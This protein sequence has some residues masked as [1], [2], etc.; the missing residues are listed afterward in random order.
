MLQGLGLLQVALGCVLASGM[1]FGIMLFLYLVVAGC[2]IASHERHVQSRPGAGVVAE[3]S[4]DANKGANGT[5]AAHGLVSPSGRRWRFALRWATGVALIVAVLYAATPRTEGPDWDPLARFGVQP[6]KLR[7]QTGF[8][9]EIDLTRVGRLENDTSVAFT[10]RV[11]DRAGR[12]V[13]ALLENQRFRGLIL[14]LYS[15]GKWKQVTELK[16]PQRGPR[17]AAP[18]ATSERADVLFLKFRVPR[19]T[20]GLFL[21]E[22]ITPAS[23]PHSLP[24]AEEESFS[25][26]RFALFYEASGCGTV[27]PTTF[28]TDP[29]YRY[30]QTFHGTASRERYAAVRVTS[31]YQ[32][33]ITGASAQ[34]K[35]WSIDLV[36][37]MDPQR[38]SEAKNLLP[39]LE[40]MREPASYLAPVYYE[41]LAR[42]YA[43][44]LSHSGEY[45]WSLDSFRE[46]KQIDPVLDFLKNVKQ[47]PCDRFASALALLLRAHLI[48]AR[49]VRGYRGAEYQG[50][51]NYVVFNNHAHAWVEL[52]V[53]SRSGSGYDWLILDPSPPEAGPS[54]TALVRLQRS[55]QALWRDLLLGY[56]E[57]ESI[58]FWEDLLSGRLLSSLAPTI[59]LVTVLASLAWVVRRRRKRTVRRRKSGTLYHR[60]VEL[61]AGQTGIEPAPEETPIEW[62]TRVSAWL[63]KRPGTAALADVPAHVVAVYYHLRFGGASPEKAGLREATLRLDA[64]A[65]ALRRS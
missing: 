37:R 33:R 52:L 64:L 1:I 58:N 62:A 57:G 61:L 60:L 53:P 38:F 22:P 11:E 46:D 28:L 25:P 15:E 31:S 26:R 6:P 40:R 20:N 29:E 24:V 50:D 5:N 36:R 7:L 10:V 3:T 65:Q 8:S 48:P 19:E 54:T 59:G 9:D 12:P 44:Y 2:A 18:P 42:L 41:P 49:L 4:Q 16:W 45:T 39:Q 30:V 13:R 27:M 35:E 21:A 56:R 43:D 32:S 63:E 23:D 55:S 51:G 17:V 47:G 14:D 34:L